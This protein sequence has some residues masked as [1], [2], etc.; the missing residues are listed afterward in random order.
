[1]SNYKVETTQL[2]KKYA[3]VTVEAESKEEAI[4]KA[5]ALPWK[6]FHE[7]ESGDSLIWEAK[8]SWSFAGFIKSLFK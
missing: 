3:C 5:K 8:I 4:E 2:S 1:M 6:D 7:S